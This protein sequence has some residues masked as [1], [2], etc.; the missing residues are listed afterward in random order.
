V[1]IQG[2]IYD[3]I[4]YEIIIKAGLSV[5]SQLDSLPTRESCYADT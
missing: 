1:E 2:Q 3:T 5:A 4:P